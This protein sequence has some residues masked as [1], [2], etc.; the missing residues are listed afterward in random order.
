MRLPAGSDMGMRIER[1]GGE[2]GGP[3]AADAAAVGE[4]EGVVGLVDDDEAVTAAL[5]D[6]VRV[7]K[8]CGLM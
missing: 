2:C 1:E 7:D 6:D 3:R 4:R 5:D 8:L